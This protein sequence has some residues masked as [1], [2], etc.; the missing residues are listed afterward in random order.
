VS[1]AEF[2]PAAE[3]EL[4]AAAAFYAERALGL[5]EEF[6]GEVERVVRRAAEA[7]AEG[8]PYGRGIRRMLLRRFP[9]GVVYRERPD[10]PLEILAVMHLRRRPG[11][12]RHRR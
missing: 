2:H 6:L 9:F 12:W 10:R 7:P 5:G 8:A 1:G 11:Y 4:F 3:A